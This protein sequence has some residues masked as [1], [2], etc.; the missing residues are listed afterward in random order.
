MI[1]DH[2][3]IILPF[4]KNGYEVHSAVLVLIQ[5]IFFPFEKNDYGVRSV[6]LLETSTIGFVKKRWSSPLGCG[7]QK[8]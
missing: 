3:E 8:E 4:E 6:V 7:G 5:L 2:A 1:C